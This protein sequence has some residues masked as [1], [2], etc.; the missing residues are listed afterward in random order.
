[1]YRVFLARHRIINIVE[2]KLDAL[3]FRD[4]EQ[5]TWLRKDEFAFAVAAVRHIT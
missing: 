4:K 1:M 5:W 3:Q 2:L